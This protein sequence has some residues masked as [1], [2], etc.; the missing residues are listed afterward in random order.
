MSAPSLSIHPPVL[1]GNTSAIPD[2]RFKPEGWTRSWHLGPWQGKFELRG[3]EEYLASWFYERL[4]YHLEEHVSGGL[5]WDGMVYEMELAAAG[6]IRRRSLEKVLNA[7]KTIYTTTAG[8]SAETGWY[9]TVNSVNR[10][11]RKEHV[12]SIG[13][14]PQA[15]AE[16]N[17]Q[18]ILMKNA[19]PRPVP[20]GMRPDVS[21]P[22]LRVTVLGYAFTA[23]W[24]YVSTADGNT[25]DVSAWIEAIAGTDLQFLR[26]GRIGGNTLPVKRE[27]E[28]GKIRAWDQ[29][30]ELADLGD[31]SFNPWLLYVDVGRRLIYEPLPS[32]PR[33]FWRRGKLYDRAA[34]SQAVNPWFVRPAVVR[35]LSFPAGSVEPGSHF[36]DSRDAWLP[37]V[38][39]SAD[40]QL[41]LSE[42]NTEY[43][44]MMRQQDYYGAEGMPDPALAP[45]TGAPG[46]RKRQRQK[47]VMGKQGSAGLWGN[48]REV[49]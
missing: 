1:S 39:V 15:A 19:W 40:G 30:Q 45:H 14:Y 41:A 7:V 9:T 4:G 10:Y 5:T 31:T 37:Q 46:Y 8:A 35:D 49:E 42:P 27:L 25:G 44:E 33:Y 16:A 43:D 13:E 24:K 48:F 3:R 18:D 36:A 22:V 26:I 29:L 12:E 20:V 34:T 23:N 47:K 38:E 21:E 6:S 32:V 28:V 11:G 2:P 17:A